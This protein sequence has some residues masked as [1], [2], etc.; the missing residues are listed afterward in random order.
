VEQYRH[1]AQCA[2]DAGFDGVEIHSANGYLLDQFLRDSTNHRTD[3][4]G[5][6][7][8]NRARIVMEVVQA[9]VAVW[10]ASRVGIRLSPV[11]T[12]A[13][14][15]ID[16]QVMQ[17]YGYLV[18]QLAPLGLMY[19]HMIEG[20]TG[21]SRTLPAGVDL[22]ALRQRFGGVY[23]ANNGYTHDL[24]IAARQQHSADLVCFGRP[25]IANPD[26]V[27]RL[28]KNLPLA[29]LNQATLYGGGAAGYTDYPALAA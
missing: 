21:G 5:G 29:E 1:A 10:G 4:Y 27:A 7:S 8:E 9:V 11:T 16:S 28:V 23:M 12:F 22:Q 15:A 18:D 14:T 24:A 6:S 3:V 25:F 2:K 20:E 13:D 26:L 17:T 19:L